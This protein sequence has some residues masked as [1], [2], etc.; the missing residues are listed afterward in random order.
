M[1]R[2]LWKSWPSR[3]RAEF[4]ENGGYLAVLGIWIGILPFI[5]FNPLSIVYELVIMSVT[6][7]FVLVIFIIIL[8]KSWPAAIR[9][10]SE[11]F[12]KTLKLEE[13][14]TIDPAPLKV[15]IVG[16]AYS[17]KSTLLR[18]IAALEQI[19][20]RT[21]GVSAV[22]VPIPSLQGQAVCLIDGGGQYFADQFRVAEA[23]EILIIVLDHNQSETENRLNH[24]RLKEHTDFGNQLREHLGRFPKKNMV[25][26]LANKADVWEN[27][28]QADVNILKSY[29]T[30]YGQLW[31]LSNTSSYCYTLDHSNRKTDDMNAIQRMLKK[32]QG[33]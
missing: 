28:H 19:R 9:P 12:G 27:L 2:R 5:I 24:D 33:G 7:L 16:P 25:I 22:V 20:E 30:A 32:H 13:L 26:V 15:G 8:A 4:N 6:I 1:K 17:G 23:A 10:A 21:V 14:A 18:G 11:V 31:Q 3:L 29:I